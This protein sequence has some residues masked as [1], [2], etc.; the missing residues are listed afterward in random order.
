MGVEQIDKKF[1]LFSKLL[2]RDTAG[3]E[4]FRALVS[5]Y[6]KKSYS[7]ILVYDV[8]YKKTFEECKSFY[9][10][11]IKKLC[12]DKVQIL[13]IGNK[14]D[15]EERREVTTEEGFKFA[16]ENKYMFKE[17]SCLKNENVYEAFEKIIFETYLLKIRDKE[18]EY[19]LKKDDKKNKRKKRLKN[20]GC[21]IF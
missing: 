1:S 17:T 8:S 19:L 3:Q 7:I 9:K 20:R 15:L 13:L 11:E 2:L 4:R 16:S 10:E 18:K 12:S 5:S 6:Y 21:Q 14:S